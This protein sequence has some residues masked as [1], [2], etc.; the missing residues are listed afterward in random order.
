[1]F[2]SDRVV[3]LIGRT[4]GPGYTTI[5]YLE[6]KGKLVENVKDNLFAPL[7]LATLTGQLGIHLTYLGT[8]CIFKYDEEHQMDTKSGFQETDK[9]N[10]FGSQYSVV[11]VSDD[12][13]WKNQILCSR[14]HTPPQLCY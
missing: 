3:C 14:I 11:K 13:G 2:F 5:D 4:H 1:M 10:F 8:G 7:L 9:P 6:Q 12:G